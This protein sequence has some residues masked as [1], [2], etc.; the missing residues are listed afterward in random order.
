[1]KGRTV[2][3]GIEQLAGGDDF[4]KYRKKRRMWRTGITARIILLKMHN[5][6]KMT[7]GL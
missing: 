3:R 5:L 1:M 7:F 2:S 6:L 4:K